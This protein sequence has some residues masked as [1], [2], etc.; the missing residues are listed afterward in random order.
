MP[1]ISLRVSS[2]FRRAP[3][4]H[5]GGGRGR[6]DEIHHFV[7][8]FAKHAVLSVVMFFGMTSWANNF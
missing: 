4:L 3:V 5:A 2:S 8:V 1:F 7:L 6:A